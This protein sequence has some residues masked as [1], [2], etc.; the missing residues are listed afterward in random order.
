MTKFTIQKTDILFDGKVYPSGSE[1]DLPEL[2]AIRLEKYLIPIPEKKTAT[3]TET[4]SESK[5]ETA[6]TDTK[7]E[8]SK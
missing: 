3:K 7:T 1:I 2:D 5:T 6:K 8:E 4:K